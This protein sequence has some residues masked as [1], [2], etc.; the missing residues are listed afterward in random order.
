MVSNS[1]CIALVGHNEFSSLEKEE[2]KVTNV[3]RVTVNT[4][5]E[6]LCVVKKFAKYYHWKMKKKKLFSCSQSAN[7]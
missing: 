6:V 3:A 1:I 2:K 4:F 7:F 5:D